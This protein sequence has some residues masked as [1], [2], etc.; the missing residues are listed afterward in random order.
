MKRPLGEEGFSLIDMTVGLVL[1]GIVLLSIYALYRPTFSFSR[2]VGERLAAQQDI[3]LA[4]DRMARALHETTL[5]P[6]RLV[7]YSAGDGCEGAYQGCI[8]FV[9]A[10]DGECA[11]AFQLSAGAPNWQATIY[12]W[13]D[14][15]ANELRLHCDTGT[16]FPVTRWPPPALEPYAVMGA[17][18]VAASFALD[19]PGVSAPA[20]VAMAVQEQIP[21]AAGSAPPKMF[22]NR[23]VFVPQ[24]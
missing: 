8:G 17:R 2:T 14:T 6:G 24:N 22:F 5:S 18:V 19:P 21:G 10:R 7:V 3:R 1:L 12:V 4:I 23:T 20:S 9:T 16:T 15:V 11:G 13:R